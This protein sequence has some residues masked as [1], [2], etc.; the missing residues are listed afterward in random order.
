M[1]RWNAVILVV[2]LGAFG[3]VLHQL[4]PRFLLDTVRAV[5][6]LF[7]LSCLCHL[8]V[9]GCDALALYFS[10]RGARSVGL[11]RVF[12]AQLVGHAVNGVVPMQ[13]GEVSKFAL[14]G[15]DLAPERRAAAVVQQNVLVLLADLLQCALVPPLALLLLGG[16]GPVA[17]ALLLI[18]ACCLLLGGMLL[19]FLTRGAGDWPFRLALRLRVSPARVARA[20]ASWNEVERHRRV[21]PDARRGAALAFL[22]TFVGRL[23]GVGEKAVI[24]HALGASGLALAALGTA[25]EQI[26][27]WGTMF[28]P[29]QAAT[30]EGGAYLLFGSV[31]IAPHLGV[32]LQIV[33]KARRLVFVGGA[34][35]L[36]GASTL[37]APL[38]APLTVSRRED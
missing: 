1:R 6:A 33:V 2:A 14:L 13:V 34:L 22:A 5:G 17:T 27:S 19:V 12:R 31:G 32:A 37:R 9:I 4:G 23:F 11:P 15:G 10:L 38:P 35:L 21:H 26:V 30:A 16:R 8:C 7:A 29:F 25:G 28:V 18:S 24:L 20:Q 36:L 3:G